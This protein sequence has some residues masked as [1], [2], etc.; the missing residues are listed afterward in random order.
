MVHSKKLLKKLFIQGGMKNMSRLFSHINAWWTGKLFS[1][2]PHYH[3][4]N[5]YC[6]KFQKMDIQICYIF[7]LGSL[8]ILYEITIFVA[9]FFLQRKG[10]RWNLYKK[11]RYTRYLDSFAIRYPT[12]YLVLVARYAVDRIPDI[13]YMLYL[14][15]ASSRVS[16]GTVR[17][18]QIT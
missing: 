15:I 14:Q 9:D 18:D 13:R 11:K 1:G 4:I 8:I 17:K 10:T 3:P 7:I 5:K 12:R 2:V 16:S 6:K